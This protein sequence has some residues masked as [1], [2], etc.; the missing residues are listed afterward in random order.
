[1]LLKVLGDEDSLMIEDSPVLRNL[2]LWWQRLNVEHYS[3]VR[4]H[5]GDTQATVSL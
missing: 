3:V 4:L 2:R 1:M 5:E